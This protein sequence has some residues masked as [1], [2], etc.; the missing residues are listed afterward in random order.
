[1][2]YRPGGRVYPRVV[3]HLAVDKEQIEHEDY[4]DGHFIEI[5]GLCG[6]RVHEDA[7]PKYRWTERQ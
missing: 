5:I 4:I 7:T 2:V 1:M 6:Q 3:R